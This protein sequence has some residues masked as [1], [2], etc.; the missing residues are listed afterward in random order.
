MTKTGVRTTLA[1]LAAL[2][3]AVAAAAA[4]EEEKKE[5]ETKAPVELEEKST[6]ST[7]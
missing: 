4:A 3:I 7:A 6:R 2:T 5:A 1:A